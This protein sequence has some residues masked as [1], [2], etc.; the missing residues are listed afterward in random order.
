MG[1]ISVPGQQ[2]SEHEV[3]EQQ[4]AVE[5]EALPKKQNGLDH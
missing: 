4:E 3:P 2:K 1:F 5:E